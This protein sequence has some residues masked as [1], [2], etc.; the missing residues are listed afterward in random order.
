MKWKMTCGKSPSWQNK[1][2]NHEVLPSEMKLTVGPESIGMDVTFVG[3]SHVYGIPEHASPFD[4]KSTSSRPGE[5]S[6]PYRLYNLDVF[7]Y[8]LDTPMSLYGAIPFMYA[9]KHEAG[10]GSG[11]DVALLWL[12]AAETWVDVTREESK[13]AVFSTVGGSTLTH[14]ISESGIMDLLVFLGPDANTIFEQYGQL[15]GYT[16]L[17]PLFSLGH[18]QCRWNYLNEDDVL[19]VDAGFD[20]HDMPYDTIW[21]DIEYTDDKQYFTWDPAKFP[22]PEKMLDTLDEH[23]RKL[24]AIIDP[25]IKRKDDYWVHI[26]G[27]KNGVMV[28]NSKGETFD[29]WCWPGSSSWVDFTSRK[30]REWWHT[31]FNFSKFKVLSHLLH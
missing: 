8:D 17:P 14:W 12:N 25:H 19:S 3:Y 22:D 5:Y 7:E 29:G 31:L 24:V 23:K 26:E 27:E 15:T 10:Q 2:Q 9:H 13:P 6:D 21:L 20:Q 30:A 11:S 28:K 1:T 4:L 16:P 18:H